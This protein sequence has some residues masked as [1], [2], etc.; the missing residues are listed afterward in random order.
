LRFDE[1]ERLLPQTIFV[2]ATPAQYEKTHAGQVVE[3]LVRPTGLVDPTLLVRPAATQVDDLL[4]EIRMR[5]E[6]NERVLVTTLTK[7]MAEDLTD[8]LAEMGVKVRY[9]HSDQ[10]AIERVEI[11]RGLRLAEFDV[12]VGINLLREGLDLPEVSLVA[13]L[14]ADKEGFLRSATSLIQT[15]GR[16]ARNVG[17]VVIL[18]ADTVTG[19]M[20]RAIEETSRRRERQF[21]W[22]TEHGITPRSIVKSVEQVRLQTQVADAPAA[23]AAE[24]PLPTALIGLSPDDLVHELEREMLAA[25]SRLEFEQA[26]SLRDRIDDLLAGP[27]RAPGGR[28]GGERRPEAAVG[29]GRGRGRP[30]RRG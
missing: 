13:V 18:Y 20:Q 22:N 17:G 4:S 1:F 28:E 21:E 26:A 8:Y 6:R 16:A 19:S 25:A 12:V 23:F 11:L 30:G 2:S 29:R 7:R 5:V 9:L 24:E 10:T 3:Q 14:D 27:A 15:A